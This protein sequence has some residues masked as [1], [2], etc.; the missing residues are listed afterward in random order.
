[1]RT[2]YLLPVEVSVLDRPLRG[3]GGFQNLLRQ[4]RRKLVRATGQLDLDRYDLE[5]IPRYAFDYRNGG[6]EDRLISIFS[7]TLGPHLGRVPTGTHSV[8]TYRW[9]Q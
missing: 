2:V 4:L 7:R 9:R 8:A 6:W 5:R 1:M 3:S